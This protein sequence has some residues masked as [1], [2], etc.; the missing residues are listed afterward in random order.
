[1]AR[2]YWNGEPVLE[3]T[4]YRELDIDRFAATVTLQ[5]GNNRVTV[6]VCGAEEAPKFALRIADERGEPDLGVEVAKDLLAAAAGP[7]PRLTRAPAKPKAEAAKSEAAKEKPAAAK[8]APHAGPEGPMQVFER[9]VA[10][11][12]PAPAALEAFARYLATTGGDSRPEHRARDLARR[13][14]EAE[15]TVRRLLLAGQLAEDRNQEREWV[16]RA[17]G[18]AAGLQGVR[19]VEDPPAHAPLA[20]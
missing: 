20:P 16:E 14:A 7:Q 4:G 11:A 8:P 13:A 19:D 12:K 3:D 5:P 10:G 1:A 9:L 18:R 15:P 2:V 6:K 17:A